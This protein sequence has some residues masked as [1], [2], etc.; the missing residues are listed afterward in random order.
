MNGVCLDRL[1]TLSLVSAAVGVFPQRRRV[2]EDLGV[3]LTKSLVPDIHQ[4]LLD[5]LHVSIQLL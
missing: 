2:Y 3:L 4:V 1:A 5:P